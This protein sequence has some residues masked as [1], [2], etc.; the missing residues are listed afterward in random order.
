MLHSFF[1]PTNLS[2]H[3]TA[4]FDRKG[5][6]FV[7]S[8][9]KDPSHQW[10]P[11]VED[12]MSAESVDFGNWLGQRWWPGCYKGDN[13]QHDVIVGFISDHK[14]WLDQGATLQILLENALAEASFIYEMQLN[15]RLR[16]GYLKIYQSELGAPNY[17]TG[18]PAGDQLMDLKLDQLTD[19]GPNYPF[20]GVMHLFT[21]CG[22]NS[23]TV[24]VSWT[25]ALCDEYGYNTGVS[26]IHDYS[27]WL[28]FAHELGHNFGAQ[29]T[30]QEGIG[31][32]GGI[33]DYG[34]GKLDGTYQFN[35]KY[36]MTEVCKV[37]ESVSD[38]CQSKFV[39]SQIDT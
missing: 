5:I 8:V 34:D 37:M 3:K 18:C 16:L 28:T 22:D 32:T 9:D 15:I 14:A 26:Q 6:P 38:H 2:F 39:I 24:G 1:N 36:S 30:F 11:T 27:T 17:A 4:T 21:G 19:D 25:G 23:G 20:E 35:T 7:K 12:V 29:H 33:M 31:K 13:E 10:P